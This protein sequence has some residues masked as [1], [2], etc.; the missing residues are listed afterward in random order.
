MAMTG[1]AIGA[2]LGLLNQYSQQQSADRQR[3]LAAST[4]AYA[5]WTG[6]K[7]QNVTDPQIA[8]NLAMFG[9]A[10]AAVGS[11][12]G[13]APDTTVAVQGAPMTPAQ[14]AAA[15][16]A[17]GFG[18]GDFAK[19]RAAQT[20]A[21]NMSAPP[22]AGGPVPQRT[23]LM[24]PVDSAYGQSGGTSWPNP[25]AKMQAAGIG[26]NAPYQGYPWGTA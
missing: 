18:A 19:E 11:K 2:A 16:S 4:A 7:P 22:A 14:D 8:Q 6:M 13:G 25:W 26:A 21:M 1:L 3:K 15:E 17:G 20:G 5:P 23:A 12:V 9:S 10:G 24:S